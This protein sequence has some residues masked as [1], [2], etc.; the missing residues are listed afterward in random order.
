M[1]EGTGEPGIQRKCQDI[2]VQIQESQLFNGTWRHVFWD[3]GHS[4]VVATVDA[5]K[6]WF[7]SWSIVMAAKK[8][9]TKY[10]GKVYK[11]REVYSLGGKTRR[12]SRLV[13]ASTGKVGFWTMTSLPALFQ[14]RP[15]T[16]R[17][18]L[19][20]PVRGSLE[21]TCVAGE[22]GGRWQR[23][24]PWWQ[25]T[26]ARASARRFE[27]KWSPSLFCANIQAHHKSSADSSRHC[28]AD[29]GNDIEKYLEA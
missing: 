24:L 26:S 14:R 9:Y 22:Q 3:L 13:W 2:P 5:A 25:L 15:V 18:R 28:G 6:R 20:E 4:I 29:E 21:Q 1:T 11:S 8:G 17:R 7:F 16:C 12:T 27:Q 19:A 23:A 10:L